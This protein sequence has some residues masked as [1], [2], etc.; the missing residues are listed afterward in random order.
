MGWA[1]LKVHKGALTAANAE[2]LN[3]R[4][5]LKGAAPHRRTSTKA[6]VIVAAPRHPWGCFASRED[7]WQ[8]VQQE[9]GAR[10][11]SEAELRKACR[12]GNL[13]QVNACLDA[14]VSVHAF[15]EAY[16]R[17]ALHHAALT[18][19]VR[20]ATFLLREARPAMPLAW[21]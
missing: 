13:R 10:A 19:D 17:Q 11:Y 2:A 15:D 16:E 20:V 4:S 9:V 21:P 5:S 1:Q 7:Q 6:G 8:V 3:R 14:G 12:D 18:G